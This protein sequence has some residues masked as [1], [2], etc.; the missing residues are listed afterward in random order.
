MS[1]PCSDLSNGFPCA[2]NEFI[3]LTLET[4]DLCD[5]A[6]FFSIF[7]PSSLVSPATHSA[8][9]MLLSRVSSNRS[10]WQACVCP[11]AFP[12]ALP[13]TEYSPQMFIW[14]SSFKRYLL[15]ERR[16]LS[17]KWDSLSLLSHSTLFF[18]L[19]PYVISFAYYL[20]PTRLET[21]WKYR[22]HWPHSSQ[23][24]QPLRQGLGLALLS[25]I[26]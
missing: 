9:V 26:S 16:T 7:I 15:R 12:L 17:L 22:P 25:N 6:R 19:Q 4:K 18:L 5:P 2:Q 8:S 21:L 20:F 13:C 1:F 24:P 14:L 10:C 11:R 23:Y 3:S